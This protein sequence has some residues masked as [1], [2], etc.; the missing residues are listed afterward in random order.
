[1]EHKALHEILHFQYGA[2]FIYLSTAQTKTSMPGLELGEQLASYPSF[3]ICSSPAVT[4]YFHSRLI[5]SLLP[6]T[7]KDRLSHWTWCSLV[8]L[9]WLARKPWGSS[10]LCLLRG[11]DYRLTPP[12]LAF[13]TNAITLN[14]DPH[15]STA[16]LCLRN[17]TK[18]GIFSFYKWAGWGWERSWARSRWF[19]PEPESGG[20]T[21][22]R[23]TLQPLSC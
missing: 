12:C 13:Y 5:T 11:W 10:C 18:W 1:M 22:R 19:I 2:Y 6:F 17:L 15:A 20:Y 4:R 8:Q 21:G 9:D 14:M 7:L 23:A 3:V 16:N